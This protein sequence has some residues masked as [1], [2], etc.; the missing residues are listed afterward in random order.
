MLLIKEL[1][2]THGD[3]GRRERE[4]EAGSGKTASVIR[5]KGPISDE[6]NVLYSLNPVPVMFFHKKIRFVKNTRYI[7]GSRI[8]SNHL[9][10]HIIFN[11][12]FK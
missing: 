7:S 8:T 10:K 6:V 5:L 2:V 1:L 11:I 4:N 3:C 12:Y 9:K